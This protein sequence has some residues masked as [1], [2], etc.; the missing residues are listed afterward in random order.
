MT[1]AIVGTLIVIDRMAMLEK[2][3]TLIAHDA[4]TITMD[5]KRDR[6]SKSDREI[7]NMSDV[8]NAWLAE[9]DNASF[10]YIRGVSEASYDVTL[11]EVSNGFFS[12]VDENTAIIAAPGTWRFLPSE[13]EVEDVKPAKGKVKAAPVEEEKPVKKAVV[14]AKPEPVEAD[15]PTNDEADEYEPEVGDTVT[16]TDDDGEET[17]GAVDA[18][19]AKMITVDGAKFKRADVTIVAADSEDEENEE[20]E[21]ETYTPDEG[22]YV[23]VTDADEEETEGTVK[24]ITA[25]KITI[26]TADNEE[27]SF[28]LNKV[29]IGA[30]EKPVKKAPAKSKAAPVKEEKKAPSKST[31]AKAA[32]EPEENG[33][34]EDDWNNA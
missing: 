15:E 28:I 4:D 18:V 7:F 27:V 3:G 8:M 1:K 10:V 22:D 24:A 5:V 19:T 20:D 2:K 17:T 21:S 32:P 31:K 23:T 6:S 12:G 25:K 34:E 16:V 26:V 29:V 9:G 30:A 14:K 13:T 33:E 11:T